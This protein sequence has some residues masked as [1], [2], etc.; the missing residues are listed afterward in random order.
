MHTKY[1]AIFGAKIRF[2]RSVLHVTDRKPFCPQNLE[3]SIDNRALHDTFVAFGKIQS[4]RVAMDKEGQSR[5]YGFVQF[6]TEESAN[7]AIEKVNGMEM[8]GKRV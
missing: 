7:L 5:G 8:A 4:V 3:E 1:G 2:V 6:E